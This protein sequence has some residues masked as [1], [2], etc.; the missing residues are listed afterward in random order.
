MEQ[1]YEATA[2][3]TTDLY[4]VDTEM[5]DSREYGSVYILDADR[6]ALVD[7]G[8]GYNYETILEGMAEVGIEPEELSV[9]ALTHVHLDHAGGASILA[10]NCPNADVCIHESGARF[11]RD[12]TRI[13]AGTKAVMGERIRY[14][15]EPDPIPDDRLLELEDG[16][17]IDLGD[18]TLEVHH[19]PGHAFHQVVYYDTEND[20]AFTADAA[21]INVPSIEGVYQTSPPTDFHL[22]QCLEDVSMLQELDPSAL[23]YGHFGDRE[24]DGLL[25]EYAGV[26][27]SWVTDVEAKRAEL[28][29]DEAVVEYFIEQVETPTVWHEEHARGEAA[30][31]VRGVL[32]YLDERDSA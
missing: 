23:Y 24:A 8:T 31:N 13:W 27:D 32:G 10:E 1:L 28:E 5:Y 25:A 11:L 18:H 14:Y 29:D 16:D 20:G 6:P 22:Q 2:G 17:T 9:I 15:R 19:A 21:G 7:T 30:I 26:L 3:D 4:Y 12:P